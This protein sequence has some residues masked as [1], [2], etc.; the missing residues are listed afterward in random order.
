MPCKGL[1]QSQLIYIVDSTSGKESVINNVLAGGSNTDDIWMKKITLRERELL[2]L[3]RFFS[4]LNFVTPAEISY[5][6]SQQD[7]LHSCVQIYQK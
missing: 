6:N 7:L 3:S 4:R 1:P 5:L 2:S